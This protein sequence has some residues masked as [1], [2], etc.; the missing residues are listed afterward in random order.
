MGRCPVGVLSEVKVDRVESFAER[1]L[2]GPD[3]DAGAGFGG[4]GP[5]P[6][7]EIR[8]FGCA[9]GTKPV[10]PSISETKPA[11]LVTEVGVAPDL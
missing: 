5:M 9:G 4:C 11:R 6:P 1:V 3:V 7:G 10:T 8:W 2:V